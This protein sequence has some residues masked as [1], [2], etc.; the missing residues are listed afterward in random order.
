[1]IIEC[2]QIVD[3]IRG[4]DAINGILGIWQPKPQ[5]LIAVK[6]KKQGK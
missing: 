4:R 2:T 5:K 6:A 1:M 3:N